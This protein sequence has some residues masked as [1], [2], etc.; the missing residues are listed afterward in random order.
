MKTIGTA[1]KSNVNHRKIVLD[2]FFTTESS[3]LH[4]AF[5][6]V[7]S[8]HHFLLCCSISE[9]ILASAATNGSVVIWNLN[10]G[11]KSKQC[12][13]LYDKNKCCVTMDQDGNCG[14]QVNG[15]QIKQTKV[16]E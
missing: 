15:S 8:C 4:M 11:A 12:E 7:S 3:F 14:S 5:S 6:L 9:N 1:W 2:N 10:K 16:C 13:Y